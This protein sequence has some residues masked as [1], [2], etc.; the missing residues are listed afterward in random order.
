MLPNGPNEAGLH[1]LSVEKKDKS[2]SL[3][4]TKVNKPIKQAWLQEKKNE[5]L[6]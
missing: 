1:V 3:N 6:K 4:M 2:C 5:Q